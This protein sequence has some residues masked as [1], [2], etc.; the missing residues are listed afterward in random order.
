MWLRFA[1][2]ADVAYLR[3]VDQAY[4]RVHPNSMLRTKF[5]DPLTDLRQRKAAFDAV[6]DDHGQRLGDVAALRGKANRALA[7]EALWTACRT[8]D[9]SQYDQQTVTELEAFARVAFPAAES[10][11]EHAGLRWRQAIGPRWCPWLQPLIVGAAV[12]KV[13]SKLAWRRLNAYGV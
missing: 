12:H 2:H 7:R 8:F 1:A 13:R 3:D 10:L 5:A 11:R 9:R 6:F 4:Y